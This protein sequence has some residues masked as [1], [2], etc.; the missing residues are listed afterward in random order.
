MKIFNSQ[1]LFKSL[2]PMIDEMEE[3]NADSIKST[4]VDD[5]DNTQVII[6]VARNQ[7][8]QEIEWA[9]DTM[10][11]LQEAS[12]HARDV[13][14]DFYDDFDDDFDDDELDE[15]WDDGDDIED[16]D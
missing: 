3:L 16:W 2:K 10:E 14:D 6:V 11:T 1:E 5:N 4:L 13:N 12:C 9:I 15:Y 8:A 7:K